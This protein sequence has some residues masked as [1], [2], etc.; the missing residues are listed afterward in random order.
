MQ[1]GP[2][3]IASL[4]ALLFRAPIATPV[5]T[6]FGIMHDRPAVLVRAE[7]RGGAVGWGEVWCNFPSVG[8]EHRVRVLASVIAPLVAG[9]SFATPTDAFETLTRQTAVLAVQ[10]GEPGPLA[11]VIAGVDVAL[12]DLWARRAQAPLWKLLGGAPTV[13]VYAS[14]LN[15]EQ[16]AALALRK[17]EAGF[18]AFKLKVGFGRAADLESLRDLREALGEDAPV[19]VDANQAWTVDEALEMANAMLPFRPRWIEEPIR[20]DAPISN[21]TALAKASPIALAAGENLR[22]SDAFST[23]IA[24]GALRVV[25]PDLGKWGGFTGCLAVG[26]EAA[27]AGVVCC[28]HWLGGGIGLIASMHLLAAIGGAGMVEVDANDNPLREVLAQPQPE[29]N[30]GRVNLSGAP[31]LGVE[32]DLAA[33]RSYA[34][35]ASGN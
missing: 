16:A 6:S 3:Q 8:A 10:S 1:P 17:R 27:A 26:R 30:E 24:S 25:Q 2:L 4:R 11:Q 13:S 23:I 32:P 7:D 29:V 28:P 34:I 14:G 35:A 15:P 31:G 9:K 12:W 20:A 33:A 18:R 21:W 19:M 5:R 22:G